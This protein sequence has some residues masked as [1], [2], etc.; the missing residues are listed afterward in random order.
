[1]IL[2]LIL[3]IICVFVT[4]GLRY[5][6]F[7]NFYDGEFLR[8]NSLFS[9]IAIVLSF[10]PSILW[11]IYMIKNRIF[12]TEIVTHKG[13]V[14]GVSSIITGVITTYLGSVFWVDYVG[15]S[16]LIALTPTMTGFNVY[17][18]FAISTIVMGVYLIVAGFLH[19][20]ASDYIYETAKFLELFPIIAIQIGL[21]NIYV[22]YSHSLIITE[23]VYVL[24]GAAALLLA[25]I[26]K[27]KYQVHLDD[28]RRSY[29]MS[30]LFGLLSLSI[31]GGYFFSE[32]LSVIFNGVSY[33]AMPFFMLGLNFVLS[34]NILIFVTSAKSNTYI[35]V[36]KVTNNSKRYAK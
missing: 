15:D 8:T 25:A 29:Y 6:E 30:I 23:N 19:I 20:F 2:P 26:N 4:G 14:Q 16:H 28:S 34:I 3:S 1:M 35:S 12:A 18:P 31:N 13:T 36:K 32:L 27:A 24:I 11:L 9:I 33:S 5:Y 7:A 22:H 21:F 10:V 17:T